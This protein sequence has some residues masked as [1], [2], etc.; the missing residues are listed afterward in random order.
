MDFRDLISSNFN[1]ISSSMS[2]TGYQNEQLRAIN[3]VFRLFTTP[4]QI[5]YANLTYNYRDYFNPYISEEEIKEEESYLEN[6]DIV[7]IHYT[8]LITDA[9]GT[10]VENVENVDDVENVEEKYFKTIHHL[11]YNDANGNLPTLDEVIEYLFENKCHCMYIYEDERCKSLIRHFFILGVDPSCSMVR[12]AMEFYILNNSFPSLDEIANT[13]ERMQ[14]FYNNP[15]EFHQEDKVLIG[16]SN[17]DKLP[18]FKMDKNEFKSDDVVAC[19]ICQE[20]INEG[21]EY[22]KLNCKH[23]FHHTKADCLEGGS[24]I[25]WLEKNKF[26]PNCKSEVKLN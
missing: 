2:Y 7:K 19:S 11:W 10:N 26:C 25:N 9:N 6:L 5:R 1:S 4:S 14:D 16:V 21:Q 24:I 13:S 22:V 23:M 18:V 3:E 17:L 8:S 20:D 12:I 15:V